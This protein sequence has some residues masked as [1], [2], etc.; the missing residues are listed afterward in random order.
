[1]IVHSAIIESPLSSEVEARAMRQFAE[2]G[3][4]SQPFNTLQGSHAIG[5]RIRFE[6]VVR[7]SEVNP[8]HGG[9]IEQLVALEYEAYQPMASQQLQQIAA[10]VAT[11]HGLAGIVV[12]HSSGRVAVGEVSFILTVYA[13]HRAEG[14]AALTEFIDTLKR[15]VPIWKSPVWCQ[16]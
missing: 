3:D 11:R 6:G 8:D 13:A 15:D 10:S 12:L 16:R 4:Q 14:I 1:M 5:A 9:A 7:S 2:R